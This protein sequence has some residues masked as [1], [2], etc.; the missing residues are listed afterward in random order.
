MIAS[1]AQ[2]KSRESLMPRQINHPQ[3]H[4]FNNSS[5]LLS[6]SQLFTANTIVCKN[7]F[8]PFREH[9]NCHRIAP[10]LI[11]EMLDLFERNKVK[12]GVCILTIC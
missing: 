8:T 1:L 5:I 7:I 12:T 2:V 11:N 9:G 3:C 10:L 4:H 6:V